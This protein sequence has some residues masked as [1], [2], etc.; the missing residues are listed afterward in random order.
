MKDE[1]MLIAGLALMGIGGTGLFLNNPSQTNTTPPTSN[2]TT[3]TG[4]YLK[5]GDRVIALDGNVRDQVGVIVRI[6]YRGDAFYGNEDTYDVQMPYTVARLNPNQ[7]RK[8]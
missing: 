2:A 4:E 1:S 5:V 7:L 6:N 3:P 8:V